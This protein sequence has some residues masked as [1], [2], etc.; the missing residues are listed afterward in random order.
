MTIDQAALLRELQQARSGDPF[1]TWRVDPLSIEGVATDGDHAAWTGRRRDRTERWATVLGDDAKR[2]T[3]LLRALDGLVPL[4]GVTVHA[5][6]YETLP[7]EFRAPVT[8]HWSLWFLDAN[9][10]TEATRRFAAPATILDPD[11]P[12]IDELLRHSDS[13]HVFASSPSIIRWAGVERNGRLL[14]IAGQEVES[15]GAAHLVSVCC[16]PEFRGMGYARTVC[17]R[18]VVEAASDGSPV[19]ILEMYAANA[20]G[21]ALY[22]AIGFTE[23]RQYQSGLLRPTISPAVNAP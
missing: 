8:G 15:S 23:A 22:S 20:A 5:S 7:R 16:D 13:A 10:I 2:V 3:A 14:A 12:R 6:A 9:R 1:L 4:D 11:D 17:S 21:R 18:L 19:V